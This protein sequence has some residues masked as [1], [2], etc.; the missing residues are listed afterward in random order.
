MSPSIH[1]SYRW[2]H[3]GTA[4][5]HN[6]CPNPCIEWTHQMAS[7]LYMCIYML[8]TLE[9]NQRFNHIKDCI[10]ISVATDVGVLL[11]PISNILQ[12]S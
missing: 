11:K 10:L 12:T 2:D 3:S 5:N 6:V 9:M 4:D 1:C 7:N 8:T